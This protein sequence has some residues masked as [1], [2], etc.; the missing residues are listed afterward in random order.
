MKVTLLTEFYAQTIG[1]YLLVMAIIMLARA[2]YY[3]DKLTQMKSGSSSVIVMASMGLILGIIIIF[4]HNV[5]I[6]ETEVL[7]T[8]VGWALVVKSICWL[9]IPE[10]MTNITHKLYAGPMYYVAVVIAGAI[11]VVL[12]AHGTYLF[13]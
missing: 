13:R 8:L 5:W 1:F 4:T 9:S 2:D 3:R 7:I 12:L 11:G 10:R 6:F